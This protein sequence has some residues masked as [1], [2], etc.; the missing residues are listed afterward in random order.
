MEK[1]D[2]LPVEKPEKGP[3]KESTKVEFWETW[4]PNGKGTKFPWGGKRHTVSEPFGHTE[5]MFGKCGQK[6]QKPFGAMLRKTLPPRGL[7]FNQIRGVTK[8]VRERA[9]GTKTNGKKGEASSK[10]RQA[11]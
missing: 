7:W 1:V 9:Y 2:Q 3:K 6:S 5:G 4:G 10:R 8:K 11:A